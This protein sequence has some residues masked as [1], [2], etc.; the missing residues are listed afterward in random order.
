LFILEE[1]YV[2]N[3]LLETLSNKGFEVLENEYI[4]NLCKKSGYKLNLVSEDKVKGAINSGRVYLN[5]ENAID[6]ILEKFPNSNL[7]NLIELCKDKYSFRKALKPLYPKFLFREVFVEELDKINFNDIGKPFIIKPSVGFLSLGVHKVRS[8]KEFDEVKKQIRAEINEISKLF[9]KSVLNI[10][11]FIIE[12]MITGDEF[13]VDVYYDKGGVPVILNILKH[14]FLDGDDVSDRAYITSRTIIEENMP[15]FEKVLCEIGKAL[16]IKNFPMHI[17]LIS[18]PA[19]GSRAA[20][21]S[22]SEIIPVEINPMRFAGWCTTDLAYFA[23]GINVYEYFV[24]EKRPA[25]DKILENKGDEIYYFAIA[26]RPK[27]LAAPTENTWYK[28]NYEAMYQKFSN[29]LEKREIDYR[30]KPV[31]V[32]L[33]GRADNFFE[34][35]EILK[36]NMEEFV[37]KTTIAGS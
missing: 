16:N 10:S 8:D 6:F 11:K 17:E 35:N 27:S 36:L 3:L 19:G 32:I 14:P 34:I 4:K 9:P 31:C 12:E 29:I 21:D 33:F 20:L 28:F 1:P 37:Q 7:S 18:E 2:S 5:S 25:W 26:E 22:I 15:R 30:E 24:C 23:Y 13:A